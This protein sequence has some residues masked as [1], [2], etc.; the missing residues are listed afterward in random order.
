MLVGSA[1]T[2]FTPIGT[3]AEYV[4]SQIYFEPVAPAIEIP[5][6]YTAVGPLLNA[7][8]PADG[9]Y[10]PDQLQLGGRRGGGMGENYAA[11]R[12]SASN[13]GFYT[14]RSLRDTVSSAYDDGEGAGAEGWGGGGGN[15]AAVTEVIDGFPMPSDAVGTLSLLHSRIGD[16]GL[17]LHP[18]FV[19]LAAYTQQ[20]QQQQKGGDVAE[21]APFGN[22]AAS[23]HTLDLS[24]CALTATSFDTICWIMAAMPNLQRLYITGNT[25]SLPLRVAPSPATTLGRNGHAAGRGEEEDADSH[26]TFAESASSSSSLSPTAAA[27]DALRARDRPQTTVID[28][29][30]DSLCDHWAAHPSLSLLVVDPWLVTG[31]VRFRS[32][33]QR[34]AALQRWQAL[35][36]TLGETGYASALAPAATSKLHHSRVATSDTKGGGGRREE[37]TLSVTRSRRPKRKDLLDEDDDDDDERPF[38]NVAQSLYSAS[39][40]ADLRPFMSSHRALLQQA[41]TQLRV[42]EATRREAILSEEIGAVRGLVA[43]IAASLAALRA[44]SNSS[45]LASIGDQQRARGSRSSVAAAR[46]STS[47]LRQSSSTA[48]ASARGST[49]NVV[50]DPEE[51]MGRAHGRQLARFA[52]LEAKL[53]HENERNEEAY[54]LRLQREANAAATEVLKSSLRR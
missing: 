52:Q 51:A 37:V 36:S 53:R 39:A 28:A 12:L 13:R 22:P 26:A 30:L 24:F 32:L 46:A 16:A 9:S 40:L 10:A 1:Q 8:A 42:N 35:E 45:G 25:F 49:S 2:I 5:V 19:R 33:R 43:R 4:G 27:F 41:L 11:M 44:N 7:S 3:S 54:R 23:I 38:A 48:A 21:A 47:S 29:F 50:S 31:H 20:Q 17:L 14:Q 15:G 34:R 6:G 18:F